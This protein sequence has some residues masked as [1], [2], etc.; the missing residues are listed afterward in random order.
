MEALL[1]MVRAP[2]V[3]GGALVCFGKFE[4][5]D[6]VEVVARRSESVYGGRGR[7]QLV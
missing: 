2:G 7:K 5:V 3:Q 6:G 4:A 1:I